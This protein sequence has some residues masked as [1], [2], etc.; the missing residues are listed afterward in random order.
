VAWLLLEVAY[1]AALFD[2]PHGTDA[3][4]IHERFLIYVT[5]LFLVGLFAACRLSES[6]A[7][8][9]V[10]FAAATVSA[11]LPAVIPYHT[12]VNKTINYESFGL[13]PFS[14]IVGGTVVAAQHASLESIW[15]AATLALLFVYVRRRLR[16]VVI[17]VLIVFIG[18]F[19][20]AR[21]RFEDLG[22]QGRA[23]LPARADWVD[24]ARPAGEV[25]LVGSGRDP[26]PE[27]E[28]A[29]WNV[30]ISAVYALCGGHFGSEFGEKLLTIGKGGHLRGPSGY[31]SA[32]YA[33]AKASLGLRGLVVAR[34]VEGNEVLV[35]PARGSVSVRS[36]AAA[37]RCE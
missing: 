18:V 1:D 12:V 8:A 35:I 10:Y 25:V 19:T 27:W 22:S 3:P 37:R 15:F 7:S 23:L 14:R 5:P 2:V 6:K 21:Q 9:R 31:L 33:V 20:I 4:R 26:S 11:F 34:N 16:A 17:L 13:H 29:Y 36:A 32:P 30:S 28:T 24:R